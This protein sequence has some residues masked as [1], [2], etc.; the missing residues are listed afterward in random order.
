MTDITRTSH[1]SALVPNN[2]LIRPLDEIR[3]NDV[4]WVEPSEVIVTHDGMMYLPI[5]LPAWYRPHDLSLLLVHLTAEEKWEVRPE[6]YHRF[7]TVPEVPE[8]AWYGVDIVT[9]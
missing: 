1:R 6:G 7:E 2:N 9:V 5:K 4:V 3:P 8:G